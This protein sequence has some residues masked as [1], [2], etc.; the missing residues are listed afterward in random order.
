[1]PSRRT[2][3]LPPRLP[4]APRCPVIELEAVH[5]DSSPR[6]QLEMHLYWGHGGR[7]GGVTQ[8][9]TLE[10]GFGSQIFRGQLSQRL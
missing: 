3:Q 6:A 7:E 10:S 5:R 2:R 1:M 9:H 4:A 8:S